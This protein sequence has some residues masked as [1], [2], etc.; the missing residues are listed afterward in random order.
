MFRTE[1]KVSFQY[2]PTTS[3]RRNKAEREMRTMKNHLTSMYAS[4]SPE[5]PL[6]LWDEMLPQAEIT[7][8]MLKAFDDDD[9]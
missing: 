6:Y 5:F 3:H 4:A 2:V 1:L 8:N 9:A 7:I